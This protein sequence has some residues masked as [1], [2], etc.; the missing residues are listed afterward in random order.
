MAKI[1]SPSH[2]N[3]GNLSIA[4]GSGKRSKYFLDQKVRSIQNVE[5]RTWGHEALYRAVKIQ[6]DN[7][8]VIP[9]V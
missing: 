5:G 7:I 8:N 2:K 9:W 4:K 3:T 1:E 6:S